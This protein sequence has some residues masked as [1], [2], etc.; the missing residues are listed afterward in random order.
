[1][2]TLRIVIKLSSQHRKMLY[3]YVEI[4]QQVGLE[5]EGNK[6]RVFSI[7]DRQVA[8]KH[9]IISDKAFIPFVTLTE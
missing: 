7:V 5:S 8:R 3:F 1:M 6:V 2:K 4:H 9:N